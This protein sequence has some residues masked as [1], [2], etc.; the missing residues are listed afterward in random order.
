MA[1]GQLPQGFGSDVAFILSRDSEDAVNPVTGT[2]LTTPTRIL[3]NNPRRLF[4]MAVNLSANTLFLSWS[5]N[6]SST[7]GIQWTASGGAVSAS[8][9]ED[10]RL[11]QR[12]VFAIANTASSAVFVFEVDSTGPIGG[13]PPVTGE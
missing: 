3:A 8:I 12:E 6:V 13:A 10:W 7:A 9:L 11:V 5:G 2:V 4:W 1:L